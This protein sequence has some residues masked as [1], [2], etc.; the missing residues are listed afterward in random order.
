M[1]RLL[2][3]MVVE[4]YDELRKAMVDRLTREG[5]HVIGVPMAEDVDDA[6]NRFV[7]DLYIID[8]N[9]PG[10]DGISLAKRIRHSY[11]TVT[12][13]LATARVEEKDRIVGYESGANLY[14]PKPFS[15]AELCAVIAGI[16]QRKGLGAEDAT[17]HAWLD[18]LS[19]QFIGPAGAVKLTQE[20]VSLMGAFARTSDQSLERW[21]ILQYLASGSELS[22]ENFKVRIS[23]L[24]KKLLDSGI[25]E[26]AI[27]AI[28]DLGY[29]L[30]FRI[31][32]RTE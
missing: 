6:P 1:T 22:P 21:Q 32:V 15:M 17:S 28:R 4:D 10:E 25:E 29:K 16:S 26:P 30:C 8:L 5:H 18:T 9:L 2:N 27:K 12:V 20:E 14:M 24:R 19:M 23:R 13:I 3:I 7:P 11:P 31:V